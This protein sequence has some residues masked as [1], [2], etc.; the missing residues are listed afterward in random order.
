MTMHPEEA[1]TQAFIT[2]QQALDKARAKTT[3]P[4]VIRLLDVADSA[5]D[6]FIQADEAA[7]IAELT[8]PVTAPGRGC[9]GP[10]R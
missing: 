10:Q 7:A 2:L 8:G 6:D 1:K 9:A 5:L 3:D 4:D